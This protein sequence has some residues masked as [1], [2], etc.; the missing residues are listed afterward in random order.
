MPFA[1]QKISD[2]I[3]KT[4]VPG[5]Q[6]S[7]TVKTALQILEAYETQVIAVEC[8]ENFVGTFSR[9]DFSR[10]VIRNNLDP[11]HTTLYEAMTLNPPS[12]SKEA[13]V[14][15]AYEIMVLYRQEYIPVLDG[16]KLY[17][18]ACMRDLGIDMMKLLSDAEL[19]NEILRNYIH[20]GESYAMPNNSLERLHKTK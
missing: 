15:D 9:D 8:D 12:L 19:E 14:K 6:G 5:L 2:I 11:D 7:E 3:K 1:F 17:G 18:I 20:T 10:N 13:C 4:P 16:N